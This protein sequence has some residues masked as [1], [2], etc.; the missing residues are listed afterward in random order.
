MGLEWRVGTLSACLGLE[1]LSGALL[2]AA[3]LQ[4]CSSGQAPSWHEGLLL[5]LSPAQPKQVGRRWPLSDRG[6]QPLLPWNQGKEASGFGMN[7]AKKGLQEAPS[8]LPEGR[9][10]R[11]PALTS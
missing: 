8:D 7:A 3:Q 6:M 4:F 10:P 11:T 2:Q 5:S 9:N 1:G